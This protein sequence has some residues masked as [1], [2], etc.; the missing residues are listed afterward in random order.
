MCNKSLVVLAPSH[1][2]WLYEYVKNVV[3]P[4]EFNRVYIVM[5]EFDKYYTFYADSGIKVFTY[6]NENGRID[7]NSLSI[8]R[9]SI[10]KCD[11]LHVHF[12]IVSQRVFLLLARVSSRVIVSFWG[13]DLFDSS[14]YR[15][16]VNIP[17]LVRSKCI[18]VINSNMRATLNRKYWALFRKKIREFDFGC[19]VYDSIELSEN[20][21]SI[22]DC[23]SSF[24]TLPSKTVI[25][26]GYNS[27]P[28]QQHLRLIEVLDSLSE[29][30]KNSIFVIVP[31]GYGDGGEKYLAEI[32]SALSVTGMEHTVLKDFMEYDR[33]A[34]LRRATDIFL[35]AQTTDAQSGSMMEFLY[36]QS[37]VIKPKWLE[38]NELDS[39]GIKYCTYEVF[40]DILD[41]IRDIINSGVN[42]IRTETIKNKEIL[43][44]YNSW[45]AVFPDWRSLYE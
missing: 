3:N 32:K 38:Y 40:S 21:Y 36:A 7:R 26:V 8:I 11:Y 28:Q 13:S 12:A 24:G 6:L 35:Y 25:C 31:F 5:P 22:D 10:Q 44:R 27:R 42:K 2:I 34:M 9:N 18:Q 43:S 29:E 19:S 45:P 15:L 41:I 23:K 39:L 16:I 33:V 37:I 17:M 14:V 30:E 4:L 20:K 1:T